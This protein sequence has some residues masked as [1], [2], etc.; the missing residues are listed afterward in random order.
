M[1]HQFQKVSQKN[2]RLFQEHAYP[3]QGPGHLARPGGSR[4]ADDVPEPLGTQNPLRAWYDQGLGRGGA[5]KRTNDSEDA[6]TRGSQGCE[7]PSLVNP[8]LPSPPSGHRWA[9]GRAGPGPL[10]VLSSSV[11]PATSLGH[12][13][14][15]SPGPSAPQG[16]QIQTGA[17]GR[18]PHSHTH[19]HTFC[20]AGWSCLLSSGR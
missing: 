16:P 10:S 1:S 6:L 20:T 9:L 19:S 8:L 3:S 4:R 7:E 12:R 11:P 15:R 14:A 2:K 18:D 17:G 5:S 13:F